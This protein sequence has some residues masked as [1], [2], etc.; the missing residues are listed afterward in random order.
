M[1]IVLIV[2]V[3]LFGMNIDAQEVRKTT[4]SPWVNPG[5]KL[6]SPD[7]PGGQAAFYKYISKKLAKFHLNMSFDVIVSFV[8][9][10]DGTLGDIVMMKGTG[11]DFDKEVIRIVCRSKKWK[12]GTLNGKPVR[13]GLSL[14][15][16]FNIT[17]SDY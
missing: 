13:V 17:E 15:I 4:L 5:D 2:L 11:L 1:K 6:I 9:E 3:L 14:P 12:P 10:K 8:V 16:R 7:Y